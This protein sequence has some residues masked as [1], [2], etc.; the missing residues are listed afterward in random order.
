VDKTVA[1]TELDIERIRGDFPMLSAKMHDKPLSYLDNAA[2]TLKPNSVIERVRHFEADEYS[3]VHRGVYRLGAEATEHFENARKNVAQFIGADDPK[4]VIFTSGTTQSI[5]LVAHSYGRKFIKRGDEIIITNIEHHANIVPWQ[6]VCRETGAELKVVPVND[7]GELVMEEYKKLLSTKTKLVAV[8]HVSNALGTVH[9]VEEIVRLAHDA[10][11]LVLID[12]AQAAPH[13]KINVSE[14]DCDFYA[15]SGH[16]MYGPTGIGVL[17][18]KTET[19]E[20]MPPYV[21]GGEMINYVTLE[22]TE[23]AKPPARF[24]A[25]TPPITQ[26]IGL[27]SAIDYL[28]ETGLEK[29]NAY[30][31]DLLHYATSLL[32]GIPG[33]HIIGT[34]ARKAA[35]ISF[36]MDQ[37]HPHDVGTILDTEGIAVRAGHHCAQPTMDRFNVPATTRASFSFYN[38]FAEIDRLAAGLRKVVEVFG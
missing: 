36:V 14:L 20:S 26:V 4:Q 3:T 33:L 8:A 37:A 7:S 21:T 19:L 35:I 12:G 27:S 29:I 31:Q 28:T 22:K 25:G 15:L 11:A 1:K 6:M 18:G 13:H 16:K 24:E 9:P 5:N 2:T 17:Y 32:E 38:T 23:F 34:A 30:E 10:G